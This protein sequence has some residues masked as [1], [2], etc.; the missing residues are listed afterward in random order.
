[1]Q[2]NDKDKY[3]ILKT[4]L[5]SIGILAVVYIADTDTGKKSNENTASNRSTTQKANR[6]TP[7]PVPEKITLSN[8]T[9]KDV[10]GD[11]YNVLGEAKNNDT[12]QHDISLRATFYDASG[13]ILGTA[14]GTLSDIQPGET[15]TYSL[16]GSD[17]IAGYARLKVQVNNLL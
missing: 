10:E 8:A 4:V 5:L 14:V 3:L 16:T 9:F 1:M 2:G 15:K 7:E 17:N 11:F 12:V 6:S 13:N